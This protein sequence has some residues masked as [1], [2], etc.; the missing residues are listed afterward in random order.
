MLQS[1]GLAVT[2]DQISA[3]IEDG[4]QSRDV[5]RDIGYLRRCSR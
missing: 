5:C 3:S 1:A 2:D 4:D